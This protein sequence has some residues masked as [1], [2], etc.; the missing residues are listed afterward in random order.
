MIWKFVSC[1]IYSSH[2][3]DGNFSPGPNGV[4]LAHI[5]KTTTLL[6]DATCGISGIIYIS[7][8]S[9][10]SRSLNLAG[11]FSSRV[12]LVVS[13]SQEKIENNYIHV[14]YRLS[15]EQTGRKWLTS[16]S[17]ADFQYWVYP[18]SD[19]FWRIEPPI[20]R[21]KFFQDVYLRRSIVFWTLLKLLRHSNFVSGIQRRN[22]YVKV[23]VASVNSSLRWAWKKI[24]FFISKENCSSEIRKSNYLNY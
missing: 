15:V 5:G 10:F 20:F 2:C 14:C 4:R 24:A 1:V 9:N 13:F 7:I 16:F 6:S 23:L 18:T 22:D 19:V 12:L 21:Q 8:H 3:N 11:P 17:V